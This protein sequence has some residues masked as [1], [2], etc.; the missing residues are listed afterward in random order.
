MAAFSSSFLALPQKEAP[1]QSHR[2]KKS[3]PLFNKADH[4]S[5]AQ[6]SGRMKL[7]SWTAT[8]LTI[9]ILLDGRMRS[10]C[11]RRCGDIFRT[12][13]PGF[14]FVKI[15]TA[16]RCSRRI[17]KSREAHRGRWPSAKEART[18]RLFSFPSSPTVDELLPNLPVAGI[19]DHF[20]V[21][22]SK[23][24]KMVCFEIYELSYLLVLF[25]RGGCVHKLT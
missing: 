17:K 20:L 25:P 7:Q 22:C 10:L 21:D 1:D 19:F 13:H 18:T 15:F 24:V 16:S 3:R 4:Q 2:R 12:R 5:K 11:C 8:T 14:S 6:R 23:L 9:V